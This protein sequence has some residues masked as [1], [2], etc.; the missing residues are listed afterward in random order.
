MPVPPE[1]P[2]HRARRLDIAWIEMSLLRL[3]PLQH[4]IKDLER[5][6]YP[7]YG[8]EDEGDDNAM[9]TAEVVQEYM[10]EYFDCVFYVNARDNGLDCTPYLTLN[11]PHDKFRRRPLIENK[12]KGRIN[13]YVSAMSEI[14]EVPHLK[15]MVLENVN[16]NENLL[17]RGALLCICQVMLKVYGSSA[18]VKNVV[19]PMVIISLMGVSHGRILLAH[20]DGSNL[21]IRKT[22]LF[23]L[24]YKNIPALRTMLRWWGSDA[25][26]NTAT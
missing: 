1:P 26:G 23:D 16:G 7:T 22:E 5:L 8:P 18:Y 2:E 3:E 25:T 14:P 9:D 19:M 20:H 24:R 11:C 21:V 12:E 13:W 6:Q 15:C 4:D 10:R 17:N